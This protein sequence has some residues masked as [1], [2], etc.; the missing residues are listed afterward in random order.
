MRIEDIATAIRLRQ[1]EMQELVFKRRLPHEE[2]TM[3]IGI[4][5]G[6]NDALSIIQDAVKKERDDEDRL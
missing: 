1:R 4:W 2:Y 5:T 3:Q 6:L